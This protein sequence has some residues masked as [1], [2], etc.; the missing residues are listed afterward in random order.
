LK[1]LHNPN[2]LALLARTAAALKGKGRK[3]HAE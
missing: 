2:L 1:T 3:K